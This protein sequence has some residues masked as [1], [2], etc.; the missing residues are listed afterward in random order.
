M[1]KVQQLSL[2]SPDSSCGLGPLYLPLRSVMAMRS[3]RA[4]GTETAAGNGRCCARFHG[5]DN[6]FLTM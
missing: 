6:M 2:S 4:D 3:F 1:E 5:G